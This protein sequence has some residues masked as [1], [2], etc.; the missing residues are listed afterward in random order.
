MSQIININQKNR[1]IKSNFF[2][3]YVSLFLIFLYKLSFSIGG[4]GLSGNYTFILF[5][6]LIVFKNKILKTSIF[7]NKYIFIYLLIFLVASFYQFWY[8]DF[9][10]RRVVSLILFLSIFS[11][12]FVDLDA[13]MINSFKF[14]LILMSVFLSLNT[15]FTYIQLGGSNLGSAAK[16]AVGSQRYG[17]VYVLSFWILLFQQENRFFKLLLKYTCLFI[18]FIGILLTFSRSGLVAMI[19]SALIFVLKTII[20]LFKQKKIQKLLNFLYFLLFIIIAAIIF[21]IVFPEILNFFNSRLFIFFA[22]G[23][24]EEM[25]LGNQD[26]SEGYRIYIL[27]LITQFVLQNPLTGSGF[28]GV[29]IL[30]EDHSGSSHNQYT[31]LL[32]RT[33]I[34]G[35]LIYIYMLVKVS[36]YLYKPH[37]GIFWGLIGVFIYGL[38]HETFKESHGGFILAFLFGM[39]ATNKRI[40]SNTIKNI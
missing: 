39:Y 14:A 4:D 8:L 27:K 33:G 9:F 5:P 22:K 28:L 1:N 37:P 6:L 34:I 21:F 7:F 19:A 3:L 35:F 23:G 29:W 13:E 40:K 38:F 11:Y 18:I 12:C 17:F 16:D 20:Y 36:I 2:F 26:G 30:F 15:I 10:I 25:D 24:V 31:D 32:F